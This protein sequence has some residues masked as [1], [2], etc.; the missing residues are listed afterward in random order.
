MIELIHK[1]KRVDYMYLKQDEKVIRTAVNKDAGLLLS[2]WN[3]GKVMEHAGFPKGLNLTKEQVLKQIALSSDLIELCILEFEGKPIGEMHYRINE[4]IATIGIK[5]TEADYQNRGLGTS[6]T[7]IFIDYLFKTK[8]ISKIILDTNLKNIRAQK[9]YEK[10]GFKKVKVN[11]D[12]WKDQLGNLQSSVDYEMTLDD[13][14]KKNKELSEMS[15]AELWQLFPIFLV[16]YNIM[17][18][19]YFNQEKE[20]LLRKL[21]NE[22]IIRISHVGSTAIP[23]M[24]AK[25]IVDIL[26]EVDMDLK[27]LI[28]ELESLDYILMNDKNNRLVFNKG[29]TKWG[30]NKKVFHLHVRKSFDHD[31]LYFRDYLIENKKLAKEYESLKVKL[32]KEFK[33]DRDGYTSAKDEIANRITKEGKDFFHNKYEELSTDRLILR[34][35]SLV[36]ISD[37]YNNFT[38]EITTYM[39]PK[40]A[41]NINETNEVV[42][43]MMEQRTNNTDY[44]YAI[45]N[46]KN[47]EFIGLVGLHNLKTDMPELGIWTKKQSHGNHYGKEAIKGLITYAKE[48]GYKKLVY[49]VDRRNIASKKIPLSCK[50]RL[51]N[52]LELKKNNSGDIL[53]IET[54]EIDLE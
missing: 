46:K 45:L 4:G 51:V 3:D 7:L 17:W 50:G 49:P 10:V 24:M 30:F 33:H 18:Q 40:P 34:P 48:L 43:K 14:N 13:Y 28:K 31:E 32:G 42:T 2:W 54:Y 41:D 11:K 37:V 21:K 12:A 16:P 53:E 27:E 52:E 5:I 9:L 44:V 6:Y 35:I 47:Y 8:S 20:F 26:L 23:N 19:H 25:D 1:K 15:I 38:K 36:N 29:Y 39:Y 22:K